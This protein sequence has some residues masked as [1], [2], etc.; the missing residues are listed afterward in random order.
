MRLGK[1]RLR[2]VYEIFGEIDKTWKFLKSQINCKC[3]KDYKNFKELQLGQTITMEEERETER[4]TKEITWERWVNELERGFRR[5]Q[6]NL[7]C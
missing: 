4:V 2:V 5:E 6:N 7:L 1:K 3:P